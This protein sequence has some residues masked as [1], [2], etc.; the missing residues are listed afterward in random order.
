MSEKIANIIVAILSASVFLVVVLFVALPS[1]SYFQDSANISGDIVVGEANFEFV[2]DLPLFSNLT[3]FIGGEIIE[4]V[5]VVNARDKE[6][7]NLTNLI[8]C[9]LRFKL[10]GSSS[11]IPNVDENLF[12]HF[13]EY[14]YYNNTFVV[15]QILLL[16]SSFNIDNAEEQ[17]YL[18]GIDLN[19]EVEIMQATKSMVNSVFID[20]PQNWIDKLS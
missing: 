17:E 4:P 15:G 19:V 13:G 18:N 1:I 10:V 16:I 20:A 14:Y 3:N 8:D 5:S 2:N 11:V 6:G 12:T 9:Y 7:K